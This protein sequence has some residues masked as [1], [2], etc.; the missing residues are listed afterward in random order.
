[1]FNKIVAVFF[2]STLLCACETMKP[3][4]S[5]AQ[6]EQSRISQQVKSTFENAKPCID[7]IRADPKIQRVWTELLY[8]SEDAANKYALMTNKEKPTEEQIEYLK[9]SVPILTKCRQI[10]VNGLGGTPYLA[11]ILKYNN[12]IDSIYLRLMRGEVTIGGANEEKSNAVAQQRSDWAKSATELDTRLRAMHNEEM[13]GR[14][15]AAAAMLPY[16]LQQQQ[17]QQMQQQLLYQQ[18]MQSI[19][20][21]RPILVAPTIN[22]TITTNC[23]TIG[24]QVNCTS[25]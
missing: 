2:V 18:Q 23:T 6:F 16:F 1:M 25:R 9:Q 11:V 8:E 10:I 17:N 24:N 4:Q 14:R 21:N 3:Q 15:Q 12:T 22:P 20:N 5:E 19:T 13:Q 7:G